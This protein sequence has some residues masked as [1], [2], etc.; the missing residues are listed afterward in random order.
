[1]QVLTV[2]NSEFTETLCGMSQLGAGI[3]LKFEFWG[4]QLGVEV[5]LE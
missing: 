4:G 5:C 3:G 1:M 2:F